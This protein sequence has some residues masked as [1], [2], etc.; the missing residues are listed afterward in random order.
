MHSYQTLN[1]FISNDMNNSNNSTE[2]YEL[3]KI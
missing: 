1:F 2:T 3:F